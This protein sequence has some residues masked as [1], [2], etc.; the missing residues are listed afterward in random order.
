[1]SRTS[2]TTL[3][4]RIAKRL[5][6]EARCAYGGIPWASLTDEQRRDWLQDAENVVYGIWKIPEE[7]KA[8]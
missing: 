3:V 1:M 6:F 7:R 8:A 2:K 4:E 5:Q